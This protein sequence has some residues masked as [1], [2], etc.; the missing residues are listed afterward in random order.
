M[1]VPIVCV[2]ARLRQYAQAFADCFSRPQFQ[3]FVIVL[4]GLLLCRGTRTLSGLLSCVAVKASLASL[5]RFLSQAPWKASEVALRWRER[6]EQQL[7]PQVAQRHA[8]HRAARPRRPGRPC[9]LSGYT[10]SSATS[11]KQG[12]CKPGILPPCVLW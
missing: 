2:D 4:V 11:V 7:A 8:D 9:Q 5:S 12:S 10:G 1:R 3:H 6:F